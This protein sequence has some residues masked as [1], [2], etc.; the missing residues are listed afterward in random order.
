MRSN[1]IISPRSLLGLGLGFLLGFGL[2][3]HFSL[4]AMEQRLWLDSIESRVGTMG[5]SYQEV[6]RREIRESERRCVE[7]VSELAYKVHEAIQMIHI[8]H[9]LPERQKWTRPILWHLDRKQ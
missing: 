4:P 1:H 9:A 7:Q 3:L 5:R 8:A 2:G 6:L